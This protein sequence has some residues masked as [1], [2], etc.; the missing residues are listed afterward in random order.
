MASTA[1]TLEPSGFS[2]GLDFSTSA[3]GEFCAGASTATAGFSFDVCAPSDSSFGWS[4]SNSFLWIAALDPHLRRRAFDLG[5]PHARKRRRR[6][7][8]RSLLHQARFGDHNPFR[9]LP[10]RAERRRR[11]PAP[12]P[13]S[14]PPQAAANVPFSFFR[15]SVRV[16]DRDVIAA[17]I[18]RA[19]LIRFR[20]RLGGFQKQPQCARRLRRSRPPSS[21]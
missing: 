6:R 16:A 8:Q 13:P 9:D 12:Q 18:F 17:L 5:L 11:R 1:A 21:A 7:E 3:T 14:T 20:R 10:A 4:A 15:Q 19:P 2:A